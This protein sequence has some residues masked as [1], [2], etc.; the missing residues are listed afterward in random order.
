MAIF[1]TKLTRVAILLAS[2][3]TLAACASSAVI[4][5][6]VRPAIA[7][8]QVKIYLHPPKRFEE[9]AVL[10]SSSQSS[11][12]VSAQGKTN[13]VM[14]RLKEEA[15]K[16]GANGVLFQAAGNQA[17]GSISTASGSATAHGGTAYGTAFAASMGV[18]VK[19]GSGLAIYV[20]EE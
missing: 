4:V 8:D 18:M 15:A 9:V 13:V 19:T 12:A 3:L 20:E 1:K 17:I 7:P 16:I 2:L 14:R 5:G 11:W 6:K 10:E